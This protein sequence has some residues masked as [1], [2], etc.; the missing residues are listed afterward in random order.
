M[1]DEE[2]N[3]EVAVAWAKRL[4]RLMIGLKKTRQDISKTTKNKLNDF[5]LGKSHFPLIL[6]CNISR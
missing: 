3:G 6:L 1:D 2:K 5:S 4:E